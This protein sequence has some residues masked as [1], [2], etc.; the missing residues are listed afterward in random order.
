MQLHSTEKYDNSYQSFQKMYKKYRWC[1]NHTRIFKFIPSIQVKF[2]YKHEYLHIL[3]KKTYKISKNDNK[4]HE[5]IQFTYKI[6][7]II[8]CAYI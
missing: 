5:N 4:I 3:T 8:L 1:E 2:L 6:M 7:K